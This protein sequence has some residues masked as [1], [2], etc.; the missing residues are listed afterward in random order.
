MRLP[1]DSC[2]YSKEY[3]TVLHKA[4]LSDQLHVAGV[5]IDNGIDVNVKDSE[6]N[7]ALHLAAK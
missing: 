6:E 2:Q 7:T 4:V 1:R 5:L 3:S